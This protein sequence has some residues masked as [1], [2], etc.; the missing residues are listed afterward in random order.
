MAEAVAGFPEL[1]R[2]LATEY[3]VETEIEGRIMYRRND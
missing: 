2:W 1:Q 3:Q